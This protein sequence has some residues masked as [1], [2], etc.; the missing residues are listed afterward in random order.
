MC[1]FVHGLD[2]VIA[3]GNKIQ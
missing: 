2:Q 1:V 3:D